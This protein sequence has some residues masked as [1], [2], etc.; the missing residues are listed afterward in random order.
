MTEKHL[1]ESNHSYYCT[2]SNYYS[3]E[4]HTTE[5]KSF[6]DFLDEWGDADM[7]YNLLFRWDWKIDE[8][9]SKNEDENYR[10]STLKIYFMMQKKGYINSCFIQVCKNDEKQIKEYLKKS[11]DHL[12]ELWNPIS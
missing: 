6:K 9:I 8:D 1:W 4:S 11:W 2:E 10:S 12:K 3:N 5:F 7:D